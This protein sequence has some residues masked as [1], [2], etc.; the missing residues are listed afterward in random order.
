MRDKEI[1][2]QLINVTK[3]FNNTVAVNNL[4]LDV[5]RGEIFVFLGPNGSGKTTTIKLISGLLKPTSGKIYLHGM[6]VSTHALR[7]KQMIG[8][9]PDTPLIYPKLTGYE[10]LKL[11]ASI[12]KIRDLKRIET[13][14]E[15]FELLDAAEKLI[16]SYS[17]GMKQKLVFCAALLHEPQILI[18][19]EPFMG[20]DPKTIR[21]LIDLFSKLIKENKT[22]FISTHILELAEKFATRVGIINKGALVSVNTI[23]ELKNKALSGNKLTLLEDIFFELTQPAAES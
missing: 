2:I 20:L 22:I 23:E 3:K 10:F 17:Y 13:L 11:V 5:Y 14:L 7:V 19:D 6:D 4:N 1:A 16:E 15:E 8:L 21:Y 12:Y 9:V 18:I